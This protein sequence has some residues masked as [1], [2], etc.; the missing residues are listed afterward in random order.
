MIILIDNYDSFTFNIYHYFGEIG[1]KIQ[2]FRNDK[3][4]VEEIKEI[5]P[6]AIILSPGPCTP[7]EAGICV[8][9][10]K[11]CKNTFPIL[12]ICL[13][14]QSIGQ[15]FGSKILKCKEIMHGKIDKITHNNHKIFNN[16]DRNFKATRYHSLIIDK[17]TLSN[18]FQII[19]KTSND[20]IMAI[21]HKRKKIIGLQFHPES[22]G[23]NCGKK[24]LI[25]FL[26]MIKYHG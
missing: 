8:D 18:E 2:V 4:S 7:N 24:I 1:A 11:K 23:T 25:N 19:A 21:S 14:H 5:K 20:I 12:G 26:K 13:G 9:L 17:K 15:A 3:I 22:I 10:V 6:E 16:V